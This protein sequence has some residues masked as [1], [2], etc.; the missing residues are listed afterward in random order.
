MSDPE[1]RVE[2]VEYDG[3]YSGMTNRRGRGVFTAVLLLLLLLG[4]ITALAQTYVTAGSER[5]VRSVSRNLECLQCHDDLIP[6]MSRTWVHNPFVNED[7]TTCHTP[8]GEA[9]TTTIITG[10]SQ[11]WSRAR[12][13]VQWL[14]LKIMLDVLDAS[15]IS[16]GDGSVAGGTKTVTTTESQGEKSELVMPANELCWM[17][18]GDMGWQRNAAYPHVPFANGNCIDCH[19]PHAS[20][21]RVMLVVEVEDLCIRCHPMGREINRA[22]AHAPVEGLHCTN[23]HDPHGTEYKGILVDNQRDLCF[24]CHPSVARLANMGVQHRPFLEDACSDCHEPHGS[25]YVPLL[26]NSQP[27]LCYDCHPAIATDFLKVSHH[28]VGTISFNCGDCHGPHATNYSG[29]LYN[30]GNGICYDCHATAI[31]TSY[32]ASSHFRTPCWGCHTPHGSNYGPLLKSAQPE[33]CFPCHDKV[34]FDDAAGG[35]YRNKHPVRP[36]Y[37]DVN[38]RQAL[39]C[40]TSCHDPHGS[41]RTSM[42]RAYD[43]LED[44][45]CL[46]CHARVPGDIVGVNY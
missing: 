23:C 36:V 24:T 30:S 31:R 15:G 3:E 2:A 20:D 46:I 26:R 6:E 39:T 45:N 4:A 25:D 33:V 17:C 41:G 40:T 35:N 27:A 7:C 12:T 1:V 5:V 21:H 44:G 14:P 16:D 29:L 22:Q 10:A 9:V 28:P 8:H 43:A 18:H 34:D 11:A 38:A 37:W 32:D 42:M 19:S 13:L